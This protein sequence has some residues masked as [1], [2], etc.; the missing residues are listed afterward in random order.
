M[1]ALAFSVYN[2]VGEIVWNPNHDSGILHDFAILK[3]MRLVSALLETQGKQMT[4][5]EILIWDLL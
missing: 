1:L 4:A 5:L 3:V 2:C